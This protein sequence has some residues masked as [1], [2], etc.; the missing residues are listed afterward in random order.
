MADGA[1]EIMS[2]LSYAEM[3]V[4]KALEYNQETKIARKVRNALLLVAIAEL[5]AEIAA[6]DGP[7][8]RPSE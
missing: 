6:T 2:H 4:T 3:L 8:R 7:P 5:R 1:H